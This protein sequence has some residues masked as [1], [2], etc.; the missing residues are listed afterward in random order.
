MA[1]NSKK[2]DAYW[3]SFTLMMP[4]CFAHAAQEAAH[5]YNMPTTEYC[6]RALLLRLEA[7][8]IR[9]EDYDDTA[10]A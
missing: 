5:R 10:V 8:G 3:G 4:Y 2:R 6:R 9:L 7:D 1:R